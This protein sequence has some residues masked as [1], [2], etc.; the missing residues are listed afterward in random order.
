MVIREQ[1]NDEQVDEEDYDEQDNL[2]DPARKYTCRHCDDGP[3]TFSELGVHSRQCPAAIAAR[4]RV[5]ELEG[6]GDDASEAY[7][8]PYEDEADTDWRSTLKKVVSS[9]PGLPKGAVD[10]LIQWADYLPP[11]QFMQPSQVAYILEGMKG[12]TSKQASV[13]A[14]KYQLALQKAQYGAMQQ[15]R[16]GGFGPGFGLFDPNTMPMNLPPSTGYPIP[17]STGYP[18]QPPVYPTTQPMGYDYQGRPVYQQPY[19]QTQPPEK[20]LT[21]EDVRKLFD[22]RTRDEEIRTLRQIVTDMPKLLQDALGG[23]GVGGQGNVHYRRIRVPVDAQGKPTDPDTAVSIQLIEEPVV[24]GREGDEKTERLIEDMRNE[25]REMRRSQQED[26]LKAL[27][28][29]I[30]ELR[31]GP[32]DDPKFAE[33]KN[34]IAQYQ[35][36]VD[37]MKDEMHKKDLD[38]VNE[39]LDELR[40]Y[41]Q[42]MP[43]GDYKSDEFKAL[44]EVAAKV[45]NKAPFE[46]L[47]NLGERVLLEQ[48]GPEPPQQPANAE[49]REGLIKRM[50]EKGL[51]TVIRE[52]A[53][54][55][56][57]PPQ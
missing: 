23:R 38:R 46:K 20:G 1:D 9:H 10:E 41:I 37:E 54:P 13:V 55:Q 49:Q 42:S 39:K 25:M 28:D 14:Q 3:F 51:V 56:G 18:M 32:K 47:I 17:P 2:E 33:I 11:N 22:D 43:G 27:E 7:Q 12:V 19:Q 40:T 16:R 4:E 52:R 57:A 5:E 48:P 30:D 29:K 6:E 34:E 24:L 44:S 36:K 26:K 35:V 45:A 53:Q 50:R 8:Q 21:L 15:Q 31:T